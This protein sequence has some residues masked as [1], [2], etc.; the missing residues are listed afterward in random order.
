M[1][2]TNNEIFFRDVCSNKLHSQQI[3]QLE[4]NI[5]EIICEL[6]MIFPLSFF[7]SMKNL[8]I[9]LV[10]EAKIGGSVLYRWMYPFERLGITFILSV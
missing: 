9:H 8:P 2:C 5:I 10:Y 3:K 1:R 7:D 6:K 4:R